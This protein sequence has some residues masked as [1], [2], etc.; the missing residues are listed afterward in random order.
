[1]NF[2]DNS[3]DFILHVT[4]DD[5]PE[6]LPD[7]NIPD[8]DFRF[9]LSFNLN[10]ENK[11]EVSVVDPEELIKLS[12]TFNNFVNFVNTGNNRFKYY[13]IKNQL[14]TNISDIIKELAKSL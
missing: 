14:K 6:F 13:S 8:K 4:K 3:A 1:M 12:K 2:N 11:F 9:S 5:N 10:K 7:Q